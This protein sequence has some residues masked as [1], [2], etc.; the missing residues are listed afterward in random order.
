MNYPNSK[1]M[2]LSFI[3]ASQMMINNWKKTKS[4]LANLKMKTCF[5]S[6]ANS[7]IIKNKIYSYL[8]IKTLLY[9]LKKSNNKKKELKKKSINKISK[10]RNNLI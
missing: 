10:T 2:I 5:K 6:A 8:E 4:A 7:I 1:T 3:Q 9:W